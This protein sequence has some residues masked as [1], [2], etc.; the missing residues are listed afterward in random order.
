MLVVTLVFWGVGLTFLPLVQLLLAPVRAC[1]AGSLLAAASA[2]GFSATRC[3]NPDDKLCPWAYTIIIFLGKWLLGLPKQA[4][5]L[6]E[7]PKKS[8]SSAGSIAFD[9]G[10]TV[11]ISSQG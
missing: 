11:L 6:L 9:P 1:C 10:G 5:L 8:P 7:Y 4:K 3:A 2:S